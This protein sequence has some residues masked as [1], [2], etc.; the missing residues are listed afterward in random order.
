MISAAPIHEKVFLEEQSLRD[1]LQAES[2]TLPLAAKFEIFNK[3][4]DAGIQ[5]I[6]AGSFVHPKILP[7]M[8]DTDQLVSMV[9]DSGLLITGLVLNGKGLERAM[10][11]GLHHVSISVSVSDTHSRNNVKKNRKETT[12]EIVELIK[13]AT[14]DGIT[15]RAG[16]Q[17]AFGYLPE[18]HISEQMLHE[19]IGL[20]REAG[21]TE[22]N[23][24]DTAGM[25][26]P[27]QIKKVVAGIINN[28][29]DLALSLH[30]HDTRG[31][32]MANLVA[33]YES[34]VGIFDTCTGGLGGCPFVTGAAGNLATEDVVSFF[35]T[36]GVETGIDLDKLCHV[37]ELYEQF[38]QR[39]L[40]SKIPT[41]RKLLRQ[42]R[43]Q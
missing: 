16:L 31:L 5:R 13:R 21:A 35:E 29:P 3:L 37:T 12:Q 18:E 11:C 41:L 2:V 42:K 22:C 15:V 14:D 26:T 39:P 8:A 4:K 1:G 30:L 28:F 33:G 43:E 25:A 24:A 40:T 32:A 38:L 34:G 23:L 9:Q 17:C 7:Q 20:L 19:T 6:Q 10:A 36:T 27:F